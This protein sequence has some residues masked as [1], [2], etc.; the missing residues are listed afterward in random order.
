MSALA[1]C[2][3]LFTF[4]RD[5]GKGESWAITEAG[6]MIVAGK[7]FEL[8]GL[9]AFNVFLAVILSVTFLSQAESVAPGTL[10][11]PAI[12]NFLKEVSSLSAGKDTK[13]DQYGL[14]AYLMRHITDDGTFRSSVSYQIYDRT[15]QKDMALDKMSYITTLIQGRQRFMDYETSMRIDLVDIT[16]DGMSANVTTTNFERGRIMID[17]GF[18]GATP[19]PVRSVS[20]CT[21]KLVLAEKIVKMA[22]ADC[23]TNVQV[24]ETM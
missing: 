21:Q 5:T 8:M 4:L 23:T 19:A 13:L 14:T 16:P 24:A 6:G 15:D 18:G 20:Y 10:T 22:G 2:N 9:A 7:S 17:D 11:R 12:E 1:Q 3:L